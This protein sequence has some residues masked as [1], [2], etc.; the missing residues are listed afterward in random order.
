MADPTLEKILGE[1]KIYPQDIF[2]QIR[3]KIK[4]CDDLKTIDN[5]TFVDMLKI[6]KTQKETLTGN[7]RSQTTPSPAV[8]KFTRQVITKNTS[9]GKGKG[10][11]NLNGG[12]RPSLKKKARESRDAHSVIIAQSNIPWDESSIIVDNFSSLSDKRDKIIDFVNVLVFE[13]NYTTYRSNF[14]KTKKVYIHPGHYKLDKKLPYYNNPPN[15]SYLNAYLHGMIN[16][17]WLEFQSKCEAFANIRHNIT[18]LDLKNILFDGKININQLITLI[19]SEDHIIAQKDKEQDWLYKIDEE[20]RKSKLYDLTFY[21]DDKGE[22][23]PENFAFFNP[24]IATYDIAFKNALLTVELITIIFMNLNESN[25]NNDWCS[26]AVDNMIDVS[27]D[28]VFTD[29]F[30]FVE[31]F[32][33]QFLLGTEENEI[34]R[35]KIKKKAHVTYKLIH[36]YLQR[37]FCLTYQNDNGFNNIIYHPF[38]S[39]LITEADTIKPFKL[40]DTTL[41]QITDFCDNI[42]HFS[43]YNIGQKKIKDIMDLNEYSQIGKLLTTSDVICIQEGTLREFDKKDRIEHLLSPQSVSGIH[44]PV[45]LDREFYKYK[46]QENIQKF[47]KRNHIKIDLNNSKKATIKLHTVKLDNRSD[48]LFKCVCVTNRLAPSNLE[49][50]YTD[51][52]TE[53]AKL[54]MIYYKKAGDWDT[55]FKPSNTPTDKPYIFI[56]KLTDGFRDHRFHTFIAIKNNDTCI[57]NIHLDTVQEQKKLELIFLLKN[58]IARNAFFKGN[59]KQIYILG[60]FNL[61]AYDIITTLKNK[62]QS[63]FFKEKN[64]TIYNNNFLSRSGNVAGG[65]IVNT[66]LDNCIVISENNNTDCTNYIPKMCFSDSALMN[67]LILL[68]DNLNKAYKILHDSPSINIDNNFKNL[69]LLSNITSTGSNDSIKK[70]LFDKLKTLLVHVKPATPQF[71]MTTVSPT[72]ILKNTHL[73]DHCLMAFEILPKPSTFRSTI[74]KANS[75]KYNDSFIRISHDDPL[76]HVDSLDYGDIQAAHIQELS[77]LNADITKIK[78]DRSKAIKLLKEETARL[79]KANSQMNLSSISSYNSSSDSDYLVEI[80]NKLL[81]DLQK[82]A[83]QE[84]TDHNLLIKSLQNKTSTLNTINEKHNSK[85]EGLQKFNKT[86]ISRRNKNLRQM[87]QVISK[88]NAQHTLLNQKNKTINEHRRQTE[89]F[90][91]KP[92]TNAARLLIS[93]VLK[94]VSFK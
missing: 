27:D 45:E 25:S 92:I 44:V 71:T 89:Q 68:Y 54:N 88:V 17:S 58:I 56:G 85:M 2:N 24:T 5:K 34:K 87:S 18:K 83:I 8:H 37:K 61:D 13:N 69:L 55:F 91:K 4:T 33:K 93:S 67:P 86:I 46:E 47:F 12:A 26:Y 94:T 63:V 7:K 60:D 90:N 72:T 79:K 78:T 39:G 30:E 70:I 51:E 42:T 36:R 50:A 82:V 80:L 74:L 31:H 10:P 48:K 16:P 20:L 59:I 19:Y 21:S 32:N 1:K 28:T 76:D 62:V 73:S 14:L 77:K 6:L 38:K 52:T 3:A 64:F 9:S 53:T 43:S 11:A 22:C 23:T 84:K 81:T 40:K 66:S 35:T 15:I 49:G 75:L 41:N 65:K 57:V 29:E